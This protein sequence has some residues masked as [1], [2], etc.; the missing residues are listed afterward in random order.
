MKKEKMAIVNGANII[1]N[2]KGI[3]VRKKDG[4][5]YEKQIRPER[6]ASCIRYCIEK[7]WDTLAILKRDT[8]TYAK[9]NPGP[10]V[11]DISVLD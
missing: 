1:H 9:H 10:L 6:L 2:D 8:I 11:G 3:R 7:G 4:K 5:G